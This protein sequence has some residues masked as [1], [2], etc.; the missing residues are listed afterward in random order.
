MNSGKSR[1]CA[2]LALAA[3][4]ALDAPAWAL[5]GITVGTS[6]KTYASAEVQCGLHPTLGMAPVVHAGLYNPQKSAHGTVSLEGAP[7]ASVT[8]VSPDASVWL[9]NGISTVTVTLNRKAA[10]SFVFDARP[11]VAGQPNVCI[12]DTSMNKV[13]GSLEY[14]ASGKSYAT[15]TPGCALNP[16]TGRG[17]P[18]VNLFLNGNYLLN[19]SVNNVALTQLSYPSKTHAPVFLSAGKNV[20]SAANTSL[21]T[22]YYVREGGTG[23]CTLP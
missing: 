22:D 23:T 8:F 14:A 19:V 20:I 5:T 16:L 6:G 11:T 2:L 7:V 15:M 10:D 9:G 1:V 4:M 12:P 17:Q 21:S 3:A 18:Y 13:V